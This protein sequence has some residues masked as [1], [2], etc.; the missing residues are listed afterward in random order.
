MKYITVEVMTA[1][2]AVRLFTENE[3]LK[4]E[5]M[6]ESELFRNMDENDINSILDFLNNDA[7]DVRALDSAECEFLGLEYDGTW[8]I[9]T[10]NNS[11]RS[12]T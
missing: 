12:E 4:E 9:S 5:Y 10:W 2:E 7:A 11:Y 8:Y 3:E 6:A 1:E